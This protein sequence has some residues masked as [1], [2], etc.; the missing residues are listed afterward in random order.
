MFE[1]LT[2]KQYYIISVRVKSFT[3]IT[4]IITFLTITSI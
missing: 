1:T 3:I 2:V 4:M